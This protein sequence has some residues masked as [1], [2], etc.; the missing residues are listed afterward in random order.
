MTGGNSYFDRLSQSQKNATPVSPKRPTS[1]DKPMYMSSTGGLLSKT[2]GGSGGDARVGVTSPPE[3][4]TVRKR[5]Q[6]SR[7]RG[8]EALPLYPHRTSGG[9]SSG[10]DLIDRG[11]QCAPAEATRFYFQSSERSREGAAVTPFI[12]SHFDVV[13]DREEGAKWVTMDEFERVAYDETVCPP[14]MAPAP[15]HNTF[16]ST[17]N[18]KPLNSIHSSAP[19]LCNQPFN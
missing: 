4:A 1:G 19:P 10:A 12:R 17:L 11:T 18:V 5:P 8:E 13:A 16:T 6:S 15:Y 2:T 14:G 3:S 9:D 7:G